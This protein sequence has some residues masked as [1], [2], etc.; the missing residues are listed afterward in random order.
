MRL[1]NLW[2]SGVAG[3]ME[4]RMG[5]ER[6]QREDSVRRVAGGQPLWQQQQQQQQQHPGVGVG[7]ASMQMPGA[8]G[9]VSAG[10]PM[11]TISAMGAPAQGMMPPAG[12]R[13]IRTGIAQPS[14]ARG[15]VGTS[16]TGQGAIIGG[17]GSTALRPPPPSFSM[18]GSQ[19]QSGQMRE[20]FQNPQGMPGTAPPT[21]S[22]ASPNKSSMPS[23]VT[24]APGGK[25]IDPSQMPRP[26]SSQLP[27]QV[28][29]TRRK[30][31]HSV[32]P[33]T[34]VPLAIRDTGNAGPRYIRSSLNS[35]PQGK[36]LV[37]A[38]S[39]PLVFLVQ[40]FAIPSKG[41][42]AI[43]LIDSR[44]EGPL[45]CSECKAYACPFMKWSP[46]GV[47]MLCCFCG[48]STKV[49]PLHFG[50]VNLDGT[51][52]DTDSRPELG[53]GTVEH[54]VEGQ[55]QVRDPMPPTYLFLIDCTTDA[56][57]KGVTQA[58][59]SSLSSLLENVAGAERARVAIV[60]FDSSVQ[61]YKVGRNAHGGVTIRML[62]TGDVEDPFCPLGGDAFV[63]L[64]ENKDG[65]VELLKKIPTIF[66]SSRSAESAAGA[67][68]L[69]SIDALKSQVGGRLLAFICS[70]PHK[71][72]L[73]L[74]P[75][76]AGRPPTEREPLD[77]MV[78][79]GNGKLYENVAKSAAKH[80]ISI[81]IFA[82]TQGYVDLSTLSV[83]SK[84]TAGSVYRYCP[85]TFQADYA[86]FF[87]D[88]RWNLT[89]PHGFEAVGRM[90]VS[91]GLAVDGYFGAI[92]TSGSTDIQ[93]PALSSDSTIMVKVIHEE[94]LKEGGN[95][96]FQFATL[97]STSSGQ[98]RVRVITLGLPV[99][100]SLGTVFR[101]AD[102]EVYLS[103]IARKV[104]AQ[105]PGKTLAACSRCCCDQG[106][107]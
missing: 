48:A 27:T 103:F 50:H 69:S 71:G 11:G 25:A 106:D 90:R 74:R 89:R 23:S 47:N 31:T 78:P 104:S 33:S 21:F 41:D 34:E 85:F 15:H 45:R 8:A 2:L 64:A 67:A 37:K 49:P 13:P 39:L 12:L 6:G 16:T 81:D 68:I 80:Q 43:P 59:C 51:R 97:Y 62:V 17:M 79:A 66:N 57:Q 22:V 70:L 75:R 55:Y 102:L 18:Q 72:A 94:R 28:F 63:N 26:S 87:D 32:P 88:L 24:P 19:K 91:S 96:C 36:D 54:I 56:L 83:L 73:G 93:F 38:S 5:A 65:V 52:S 29:E 100:R 107:C 95:A 86:R 35:I 9:R 30:G 99:T 4:G 76:E 82:L 61:Y 7:M 14:A 3:N 77:I 46:D 40:P 42:S 105:I 1:E 84:Y 60:T 101:G 92:Y 98:R 10:I 20:A 58:V 53:H 44:Q